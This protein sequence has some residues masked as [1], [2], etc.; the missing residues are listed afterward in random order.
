MIFTGTKYQG[1]AIYTLHDEPRR[2]F[3]PRDRTVHD[4]FLDGTG[5]Y[6][7]FPRGDGTVVAALSCL[8]ELDCGAVA[9]DGCGWW[10]WWLVGHGRKALRKGAGVDRA[11]RCWWR[12]RWHLE[13]LVWGLA[14]DVRGWCDTTLKLDNGYAFMARSL[15]TN[16]T[17]LLCSMFTLNSRSTSPT[18]PA[19]NYS[20]Y[21]FGN[22]LF[23]E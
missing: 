3:L 22:L 11:R 14:C 7:D 4:W 10:W 20:L 6:I 18:L 8:R 5:R 16:Q 13:G 15:S 1:T 12:S 9:G 17:C 21:Y 23:P 19:F 2:T